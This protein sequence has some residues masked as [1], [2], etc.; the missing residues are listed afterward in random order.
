M[1]WYVREYMRMNPLAKAIT[2]A[3]NCQEFKPVEELLKSL[4][5]S[6]AH[7]WA[8]DELHIN[9][10]ME[11]NSER[12]LVIPVENNPNLYEVYL[13]PYHGNYDYYWWG[14]ISPLFRYRKSEYRENAPDVSR[15]MEL[16]LGMHISEDKVRAFFEKNKNSVPT[17]D[18][19][20]AMN[21]VKSF[22]PAYID[23]S[24]N[25]VVEFGEVNQLRLTLT[26]DKL[27]DRY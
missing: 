13:N 15:I 4:N 22:V 25:T 19:D 12:F 1:S 8:D 27:D 5:H 26:E 9:I 2:D 23:V 6:F 16:Y 20:Y 7:I 21:F 3:Y 24:T 18:R 17:W 11:R 10:G 14:Y